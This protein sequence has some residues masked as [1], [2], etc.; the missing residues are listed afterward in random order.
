MLETM[1]RK[2]YRNFLIVRNKLMFEKGYEPREAEKITHNIFE[3][4]NLD[5]T[6]TIKEYYDRVITREEFELQYNY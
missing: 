4:Y 5:N 3:N 6:R 2:T 1:K